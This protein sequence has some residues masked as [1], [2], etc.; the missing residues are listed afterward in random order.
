MGFERTAA[1]AED[2][3]PLTA[4]HL[5]HEPAAV[6]G[7]S[8]DLLDRRA[9]FGHCEDGGVRLFAAQVT[10]ILQ[11]LGGGEQG[12]LIVAAPMAFRIWR[13]DLRTASRKA[14]LAFCIRC[15][16]SAT[17]IALGSAFCVANS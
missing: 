7:A 14:W 10:F 4:K 9:L 15:Q 11:L 8:H 13:I 1:N 12:G 3:R 16:R 6:A 17:C 5:S 2:V